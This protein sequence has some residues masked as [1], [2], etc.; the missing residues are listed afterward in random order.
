MYIICLNLLINMVQ[1]QLDTPKTSASF[2]VNGYKLKLYIEHELR[3][4]TEI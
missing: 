1:H 3:E 4:C 2:K